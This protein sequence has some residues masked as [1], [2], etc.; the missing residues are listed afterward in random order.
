[1]KAKD[2]LKEIVKVY[3]NVVAITQDEDGEV[4]C[5]ENVMP[6]SNLNTN[7]W[8]NHHLRNNKDSFEKIPYEKLIEWDNEDWKQRI[9]TIN[10]L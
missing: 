1:M 9:V 10:D 8:Y 3:P 2:L 6:I 4:Y 7:M 5:F